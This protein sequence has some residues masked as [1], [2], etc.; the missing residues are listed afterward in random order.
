VRNPWNMAHVPGGSSG[1]SGVAVAAGLCAAALGTDTAGSIRLPACQCGV[2]GLKPTYGRTSLAGVT[3][4]A[5][6]LDHVGPL[7]RTVGDAALVYSVLS[8]SPPPSTLETGIAGLKLGV[9]RAFFFDNLQ[10]DVAAA[11]ERALDSLRE[12]GASLVDVEWPDVQLSNS[13]TWTII[14]AEASAYHR[15]WFQARP[16]GYSE[17]TRQ[18]L[19]MGERLPAADYVQAQRARSVLQRQAADVMSGV[20]AL[21]TPSLQITA[22]RIGQTSVEF[23]GKVREINPVFIRLSDPFNVTGQPAIS[24]PCGISDDGLPIGLQIAGRPFD[25]DMVLR[26]ASAFESATPWH[27]RRPLLGPRPKTL[28]P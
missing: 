20:D 27:L 6:S 14:L 15:A 4:L 11:V 5:W 16:E 8:G 23:G 17:E 26:I 21:V 7:T 2:V 10:P 1:G 9:P 12:L 19:L 24:V 28:Q 13:I 25:E 18:H 3:P 22:P